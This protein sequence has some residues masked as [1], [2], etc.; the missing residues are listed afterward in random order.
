MDEVERH[1]IYR[2]ASGDQSAR[3]EAIRVHRNHLDYL[4]IKHFPLP[5]GK[6]VHF[7]FMS[8][9]DN[10]CPDLLLRSIYRKKVIAAHHEQ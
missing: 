5:R 7:D 9:V 3:D 2:L 4:R 1:I 10:P 8:E 6:D